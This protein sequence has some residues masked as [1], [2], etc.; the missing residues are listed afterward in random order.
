M[1]RSWI[2]RSAALLL[3]LVLMTGS[4]L[5]AGPAAPAPVIVATPQAMTVDGVSVTPAA[6]N[7]DGCNY[8]KL[9]DLAMLLNG[10][11]GQFQVTYGAEDKTIY[12]TPGQIYQPIGGELESLGEPGTVT[13]STQLVVFDGDMVLELTAYNIDGYNYFKLRDLAW[14]L[15]VVVDYLPETD[16]VQVQTVCGYPTVWNGAT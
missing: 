9:R 6:Y 11:N 14:F 4:A 5:A 12:L 16:T 8:F 1:M 7:I 10:T 15:G 13:V 3:V 2:S